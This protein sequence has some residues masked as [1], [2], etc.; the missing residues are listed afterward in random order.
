M[1]HQEAT[2]D[3]E[4]T[5]VRPTVPSAK[6]EPEEDTIFQ[7]RTQTSVASVGGASA[8]RD[9]HVGQRDGAGRKGATKTG[10]KRQRGGTRRRSAARRDSTGPG[11][12]VGQGG[13]EA[14][15]AK[16]KKKGTKAGNPA[17]EDDTVVQPREARRWVVAS[18]EK[19][20]GRLTKDGEYLPPDTT[21]K[22]RFVVLEMV[23]Q[24]GMGQ[25]YKALDRRRAEIGMAEPH[26]ALKV[27]KPALAAD[28]GAVA[29]FKREAATA[30]SLSSPRVVEVIDYDQD[31][32]LH[33]IVSEF[34]YGE[35]LHALLKRLDGKPMDFARALVVVRDLAEALR[36]A[37]SKGVIHADFKPGNAFVCEDGR[38]KLLD[39]GVARTF[40]TAAVVSHGWRS[41]E[42]N[43]HGV[44]P[45][46]ASCQVLEGKRPDPRDDI[47]S[48][49]VVAYR[50]LSGRHPFNGRTALEARQE[51]LHPARIKR[52][53]PAPWRTLRR[54]LAFDRPARVPTM[55]AFV[56][57]FTADRAGANFRAMLANLVR[58]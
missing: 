39:F 57:G 44:T 5:I 53:K 1:A 13:A 58:R 25:V 31:A 41:G 20:A 51:G 38:V 7:L 15:S 55:H 56:E 47:Y 2:S 16:T 9:A 23:G 50:L 11:K 37:H 42:D 24:G 21:I 46:Y 22:D 36:Y 35:S 54:A 28:S 45:P 6:D 10:A 34:L 32:E 43:L 26:V 8:A 52:L 48:L 18:A 33:F 40:G 12:P 19:P 49:A 14:A 4:D 30:R 29:A 3:G 17:S 27:L